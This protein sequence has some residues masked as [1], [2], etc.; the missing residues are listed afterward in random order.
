MKM[1][2]QNKDWFHLLLFKGTYIGGKGYNLQSSHYQIGTFPVCHRVR[3]GHTVPPGKGKR[4]GAGPQRADYHALHFS[5]HMS[6]HYMCA[7]AYNPLHVWNTWK[8]WSRCNKCQRLYTFEMGSHH[9][10]PGSLEAGGC[11]PGAHLH[12]P[13]DCTPTGLRVLFHF[14]FSVPGG[15]RLL[16]CSHSTRPIL[17]A[18]H[19]LIEKTAEP[20]WPALLELGKCGKLVTSAWRLPGCLTIQHI[21]ANARLFFRLNRLGV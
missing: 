11:R 17:G 15:W 2:W 1:K 10:E 20:T 6:T 14:H 5:V 9:Q 12:L 8:I 16:F 7:C 21:S 19:T 3:E 4:L 18:Q 13:R